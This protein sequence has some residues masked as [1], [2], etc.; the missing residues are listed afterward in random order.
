MAIGTKDYK[1]MV[2]KLKR[3]RKIFEIRWINIFIRD[4]FLAFVVGYLNYAN[5]FRSWFAALLAGMLIVW[6]SWQI[7]DYIRERRIQHALDI[8]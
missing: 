5:N 4:V 6:V 1:N 8:E 2:E 3:E 7:S